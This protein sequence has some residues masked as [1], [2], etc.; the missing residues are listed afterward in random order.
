M[1]QAWA[2]RFVGSRC[3][4]YAQRGWRRS[5]TAVGPSGSIAQDAGR[6]VVEIDEWGIV[7]IGNRNVEGRGCGAALAIADRVGQAVRARVTWCWA[8]EIFA[9]G[10]HQDCAVGG[11]GK[12]CVG[13]RVVV[14]IAVVASNGSGADAIGAN[15]GGVV[16]GNRWQVV[17]CRVAEVQ[18]ARK[19]RDGA[20]GCVAIIG[21]ISRRSCR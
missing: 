9:I 10:Q 8:V 15:G 3:C 19:W 12:N 17:W 1:G 16:D 11:L 21:E 2:S 13:E 14:G 5:P 4:E 6:A 20:G 7:W 18:V